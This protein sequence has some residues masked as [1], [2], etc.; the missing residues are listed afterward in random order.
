MCQRTSTAGSKRVLSQNVDLGDILPTKCLVR[1]ST[2][3]ELIDIMKVGEI[4]VDLDHPVRQR[5]NDCT[6]KDPARILVE[7]WFD[8][9]PCNDIV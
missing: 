7:E 1:S 6:N 9:D 3:E 4:G 8:L 5:E 2:L